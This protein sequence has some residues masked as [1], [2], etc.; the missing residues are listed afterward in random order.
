MDT[1]AIS[2]FKAT[3][4]SAL[5]RVRKTGRPLRITRF[6]KPVADI[7]PASVEPPREWLGCMEGTLEYRGDI[8][9][10]T[11]ELVRWEATK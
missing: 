1:L 5:E 4:L 2:K 11:S 10:P 9:G 3:C 8:V 7:V 6:G